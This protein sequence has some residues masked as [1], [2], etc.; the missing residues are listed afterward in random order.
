VSSS[1]TIAVILLAAGRGTR[2]ALAAPKQYHRIGDRPVL[3]HALDLFEQHPQI[4]HIQPVIHPDDETRF[5]SVSQRCQKLLAAVSGGAERQASVLAGLEALAG[6][7]PKLVLI[8][9]AARPFTSPALVSAVING[10]ATHKAILPVCAVTDTIKQVN[11]SRVAATLDRMDLRTAQTPQGFVFGDILAAHR[12]ASASKI[13]GLTDDAAIAEWAGIDVH[14]IEG[15][16]GNWKLTTADDLR[17]AETALAAAAA[18]EIRIGQGFDVHRFGAGDHVVLCG[19]Q[20]AHD[21]ALEGHS[22]A[23]VA[24]HALTDAL[25]GAIG[26]ADI[27]AHFPPGEAQWKDAASDIFLAAAARMIREAG[28][29]IVNLDLTVICETPKIGPHR[30]AMRDRLAEILGLD[31]KRISVKATT[32]EGLGFTGRGE[33]IAAMAVASIE[34]PAGENTT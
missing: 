16:T 8:H 5:N 1:P 20:I 4:D 12:K 7:N 24:M 10:L 19:V 11:G 15:E 22:D 14:V 9:D 28:G 13:A 32:S 18:G 25:L 21:Q 31:A 6:V 29:G 23:D 3:R 34:L 26:E 33:G 17:R 2:A 27:G 30:A